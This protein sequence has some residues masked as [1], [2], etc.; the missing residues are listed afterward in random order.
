[1]GVQMA[2][3]NLINADHGRETKVTYY[4][5]YILKQPL[6]NMGEEARKK[7]LD[8]QHRTKSV[9]DEIAAVGNP[10]Y[11]IPKMIAVND[12]DFKALEERAFGY[13]LTYDLYSKL[14]ER[15]KFEI[16]NSISSF[17]V[18]MNELRPVGS[19]QKHKIIKELKFNRLDSFV[20]DKIS[21]WPFSESEKSFV[22]RIRDEVAS[23]EYMTR[24]AWSHSD[25][26]SGNV[27]YDPVKSRIAFID[28]AEADYRFI[29]R[30]IFAPIQ[31]ELDLYEDV[32][33]LYNKL[34][35]HGLYY[36]PCFED[37]ELKN[38]MKY[39]IIVALLKRF[40]KAA[41]DLRINAVS[42]KTKINNQNKIEY[43]KLQI[44]KMRYIESVYGKGTK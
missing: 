2:F 6:D 15:Q 38:I 26:N 18:D 12:G 17:L 40:I 11:Y 43:M 1:M 31:I 5:E 8:K 20:N 24:L 28:F 27:L 36:M 44:Q 41:D 37:R 7:W 13:H 22:S 9:I 39:R 42:E 32:Y 14:S 19:L 34:H 29:Y 4:D 33:K 23:F 35:N 16:I 30:D 21:R 25:L 3:E 10:A